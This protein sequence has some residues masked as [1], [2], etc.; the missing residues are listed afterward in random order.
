MVCAGA[1]I[2]GTGSGDVGVWSADDS[3]CGTAR[4]N[5]HRTELEL[6]YGVPWRDGTAR[7][8]MGGTQLTQGTMY[9]LGG[10]FHYRRVD[11]L[12]LW[13]GTQP[14][15]CTGRY[16]SECARIASVLDGSKEVQQR[17]TASMCTTAWTP[18]QKSCF[19]EEYLRGTARQFSITET[20]FRIMQRERFICTGD[21]IPNDYGLGMREAPLKER[22]GDWIVTTTIRCSKV[23]VEL[24]GPVDYTDID[25]RAMRDLVA[26]E[27]QESAQRS[28]SVIGF[29][30]GASYSTR[31]STIEDSTGCIRKLGPKPGFGFH[32]ED[33][34]FENAKE[35]AKIVRELSIT[36]ENFQGALHDYV[37]ALN[38]TP[39]ASFYLYRALETLSHHFSDDCEKKNSARAWTKMHESLGTR[40]SEIKVI[41]AYADEIRHG[42][43]PDQQK[44]FNSYLE[45]HSM[46][47]YVRDALLAFIIKN[48]K[49]D[50]NLQLPDL[51]RTISSRDT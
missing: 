50:L 25:P 2:V 36:N 7:S 11:V 18:S 22:Q 32:G 38:F 49:S 29:V 30:E 39:D 35:I 43:S 3:G 9:R 42:K 16:W 5:A 31:I 6:G 46:L 21:L 28:L 51:G 20:A 12:G 40:E 34:G 4:G 41:K 1:S 14:R 27:A 45:H 19:L 26:R 37:T 23:L 33:L 24:E 13:F 15:S 48:S 47:K 10:E 44:L 8:I 17:D